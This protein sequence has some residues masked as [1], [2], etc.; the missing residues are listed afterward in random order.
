VLPFVP[1]SVDQLKAAIAG[2][3]AVTIDLRNN[4]LG[5]FT[6]MRQCLA[7][8]APTGTYGY[9]SSDRNA[10]GQPIRV[11]AGNASPPAVTLLTDRTTRGA[12]E[13][14]ALALSSR[15]IAKMSGG[16]TGGARDFYDIVSL[17]DGSGYTLVTGHYRPQLSVKSDRV[18]KNGGQP[19]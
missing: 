13:I 16:D 7:V 1:S 19:K 5:D 10:K 18:A 9:E 12:A 4:T 11:A 2:R 14:F 6:V 8:V 3:S 17:P 15:G